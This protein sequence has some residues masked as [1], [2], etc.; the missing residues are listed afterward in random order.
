MPVADEIAAVLAG[1]GAELLA[2]AVAFREA[3]T[4]DA[5]SLEEAVEGGKVGFARVRLGLLRPRR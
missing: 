3:R 1:V 4:V 2:E 5:A